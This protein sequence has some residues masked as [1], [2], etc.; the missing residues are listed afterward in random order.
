M[1]LRLVLYRF[2]S[3][4][5]SSAVPQQRMPGFQMGP[6]MVARPAI[7]DPTEVKPDASRTPTRDELPDGAAKAAGEC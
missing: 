2:D 5:Y 7:P 3:S 6:N 1:H 4:L